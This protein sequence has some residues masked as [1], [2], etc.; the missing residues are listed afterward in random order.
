MLS[1]YELLEPEAEEFGALA[2]MADELLV[3]SPQEDMPASMAGILEA[4]RLAR[5][6]QDPAKAFEALRD[7]GNM[8]RF[9]HARMRKADRIKVE[10]A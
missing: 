7:Y 5:A 6:T 3:M 10:S 4:L 9:A 2:C 8:V 1:F